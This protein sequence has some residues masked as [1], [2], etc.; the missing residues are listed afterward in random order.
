MRRSHILLALC[1]ATGLTACGGGGSD[2]G[3]FGKFTGAISMEEYAAFSM[4][5]DYE[6]MGFTPTDTVNA[7]S[8]KAS[9]SG[10]VNV[11][12]GAGEQFY[13]GGLA[14]TADFAANTVEGS[15]G[16]F[17]RHDILGGFGPGEPPLYSTASVAGSFDIDATITTANDVGI[18]SGI[19]GGASGTVEGVAVAY[20]VE[21]NFIGDGMEG[22]ALWFDGD[23]LGEGGV[24]VAA[25]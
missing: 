9:Y 8:N 12:N 6:A 11:G 4:A 15:A 19:V 14:L 10:I 2:D 25:R 5:N 1:G 24:G 16:N 20:D 13:L 7:A 17:T 3:G 21:G 18:G 23:T 22:I